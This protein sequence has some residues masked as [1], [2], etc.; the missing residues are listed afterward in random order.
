MVQ[1]QMG[2]DWFR[3]VSN[4]DLIELNQIRDSDACVSLPFAKFLMLK[5]SHTCT[6]RYS[7]VRYSPTANINVNYYAFF[8]AD[9]ECGLYELNKN[10]RAN[11][12]W[13]V[14]RV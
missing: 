4:L 6:Y 14:D 13:Y 9:A 3:Y 2:R 8:V 11:A 7:D 10:S 12:V 1:P 5:M